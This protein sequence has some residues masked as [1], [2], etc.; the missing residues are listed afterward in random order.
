MVINEKALL[1]AMKEAYKGW[2][3]TVA[4]TDHDVWVISCPQWIA[5]ICDRANVPNEV[6]SLIVLHMGYL[7]ERETAYR[8]YKSDTGPAIQEEIFSEAMENMI[9]LEKKRYDPDTKKAQIRKTKL[10]F[11]HRQVW[12]RPEDLEIFLVD[13]RYES[14]IEKK[15]DVRTVGG[16]LFSVG[17]TSTIYVYRESDTGYEA[18]IEHLSQMQWVAR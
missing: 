2:G 5:K 17:E 4:V 18:Q 10:H 14:I 11:G 16:V 8:V 9:D 1:R 6:L 3:Y 12:Q 7:P 15:I 13:P